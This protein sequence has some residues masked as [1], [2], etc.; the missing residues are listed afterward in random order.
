MLFS[1]KAEY[2]VRL[3]VELGR[4]ADRGPVSLTSVAEVENLPLSYLEH[5]VAKLRRADLV[6]STRGAH[7]GYALARPAGEIELLEVVEALE[8][9]IVPME[10][11]HENP[12]GRVQCS[13]RSQEGDTEGTC[14]TKFLWM[15]VHSGVTS[16]LRGTTLD[17]LVEFSRSGSTRTRTASP[18]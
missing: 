5:L 18:A 4:Q 11:F 15:R 7:G 6:T 9:P 10:C 12:E 2:G 8:G 17:E 16:A 13:H 14:A 3:M 1:T